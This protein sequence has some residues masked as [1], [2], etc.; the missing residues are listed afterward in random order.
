MKRVLGLDLGSTSIGWAV[1][2]ENTTEQ[3]TDTH[4]QE[5]DKILGIG[6]RIIPLTVDESNQFSKGQALTKNADRTA[7]RTQRKGFDRY[8]LRR[9][10]LLEELKRRCIYDGK[11]LN[12]SKLELW[13]LRAKAVYERISLAELGR[14][15]CHINQK[16]GYRT[17][18]SDF[19]DK[20]LGAHVQQVVDR[21]REI[22]EQGITVG[23]YMYNALCADEAFRCKERTY[24]R[25]AYIEEYDAIMAC[26]RGFYPEI[27]TT[28][29][30]AYIRDYII[31]HQRP[32]KS[33]KHLVGRCELERCDVIDQS[34]GRVRNQGPKV[35]PRSSPLFQACKIWE[36]INNLN[37]HNKTNDTLHI[38]TEQKQAIYAFMSTHEN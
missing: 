21:Y 29:C 7:K 15:L 38:T 12:L 9:S 24:P 26:Q 5:R 19:G 3:T 17:A 35:A 1:I 23:Q 32:L 34:S 8:Q 18:K 33:C 30:I 11:P 22:K 16:R 6:S 20:K 27:L 14:V 28:E 10:L 2:E 37:I 25:I 36:S 13:G 31:F 4:A